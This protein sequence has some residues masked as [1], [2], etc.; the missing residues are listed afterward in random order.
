MSR[1]L[2]DSQHYVVCLL[3][4]GS[5][6]ML[7]VQTK[8]GMPHGKVMHADHPQYEDYKQAFL[9]AVDNDESTAL[10][11]ALLAD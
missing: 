2:F 7:T 1:I 9:T 5:K 8:R 11:R 6:P 3:D 4:R 10:C